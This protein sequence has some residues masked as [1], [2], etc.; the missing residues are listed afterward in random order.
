MK[1]RETW[2]RET[3]RRNDM[4]LYSVRCANAKNTFVEYK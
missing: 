2:G 4:D 3:W 1:M